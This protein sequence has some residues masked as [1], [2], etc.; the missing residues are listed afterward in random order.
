MHI[1]WIKRRS[2]P[3]APQSLFV[4]PPLPFDVVQ[5]K[6]LPIATRCV[7]NRRWRRQPEQAHLQE[8]GEHGGA[9]TTTPSVFDRLTRAV[10]WINAWEATTRARRCLGLEPLAARNRLSTLCS[11]SLPRGVPACPTP[12]LMYFRLPVVGF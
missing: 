6:V 12:V 10:D 9:L 5:V 2:R 11:R 7:H 1:A 4:L 3:S 8:V